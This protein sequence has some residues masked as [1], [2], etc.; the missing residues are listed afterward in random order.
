M[1][2]GCR[3]LGAGR[4]ARIIR[5]RTAHYNQK[6]RSAS[7]F[8]TIRS[9]SRF[10]TRFRYQL[11]AGAGA[12]GSAGAPGIDAA[13]GIEGAPDIVDARGIDPAPGSGGAPG[14]EGASGIDGAPGIEGAPGRE[15][16][17]GIE[18]T[19]GMTMGAA[20]PGDGAMLPVSCANAHTGTLIRISAAANE[21]RDFNANSP[22]LYAEIVR[23]LRRHL[24]SAK[25]AIKAYRGLETMVPSP[26][27]A[28]R[29][30]DHQI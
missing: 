18:G 12:P 15:P 29:K 3:L 7:R 9:A 8:G 17:S 22:F 21:M 5:S 27:R 19:D 13:P 10:G 16:A 28:Q 2:Y 1:P 23:G 20:G 25:Q 26:R 30:D 11:G 6:I 24:D 14:I 4:S